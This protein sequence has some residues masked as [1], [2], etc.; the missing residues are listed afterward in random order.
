MQGSPRNLGG[1]PASCSTRRVGPAETRAW[2]A[3]ATEGRRWERTSLGRRKPKAEGNRGRGM[4]G[5][6]SERSIVP[7]KPGNRPEG[8]GG[9]KGA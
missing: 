1:L 5:Q 4:G 6:E 7:R 9:G 8:P 2:P 3:A